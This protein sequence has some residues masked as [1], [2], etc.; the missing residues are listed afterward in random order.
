MDVAEESA[1]IDR[2]ISPLPFAVAE[3]VGA[4]GPV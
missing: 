1:L 3:T 4:D 2:S